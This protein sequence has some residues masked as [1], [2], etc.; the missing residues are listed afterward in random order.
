M[1]DPA[2]APLVRWDRQ[3]YIDGKSGGS[4][5]DELTWSLA[6]RWRAGDGQRLYVLS[7]GFRLRLASLL[8]PR[9]AYVEDYDS[10]DAKPPLLLV[11]TLASKQTAYVL[12]ARDKAP[13]PE[14]P[15]GA[16]L[17]LVETSLSAKSPMFLYQITGVQGDLADAVFSASVPE[18]SKLI[19]DYASLNDYLDQQTPA[20][21]VAIFPRSHADTLAKFDAQGIAPTDWPLDSASAAAALDPFEP[22]A[23]ASLVDVILVDEAHLDPDRQMLLA[24]QHR[25]FLVSEA[26]FGLLH[27]KRFITGPQNPPLA[28][29]D[30]VW[31]E[32]I[33]L[34]SI[35]ILDPTPD[36]GGIVRLVLQWETTGPRSGLHSK[37]LCM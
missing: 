5:S 1:S 31:E 36:P 20:E 13:L 25:W 12:D 19:A 35:S 22:Q 23:D 24:L 3:Q 9:A 28:P 15:F 32:A 11:Q 4:G 17:E 7:N 29:M 14:N 8:G 33:H 37:S 10:L 16:H 30:A 26:W 21:A 18:P 34:N 27:E 6:D 2:K